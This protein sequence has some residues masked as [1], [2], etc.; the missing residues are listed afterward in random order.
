MPDDWRLQSCGGQS[1]MALSGSSEQCFCLGVQ[2]EFV[3]SHP[4]CQNSSD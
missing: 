2:L 4:G 3:F 1:G